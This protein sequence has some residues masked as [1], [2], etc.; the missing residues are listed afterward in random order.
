LG[1]FLALSLAGGS[2]RC[3]ARAFAS[4]AAIP[5]LLADDQDIPV[6][7]DV[8]PTQ[9]SNLPDAKAE[10][11]EQAEDRRVSRPAQRRGAPIGSCAA[12]SISR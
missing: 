7:V 8:S 6:A 3:E 4:I 11:E 2:L 12:K 9:S 10:A 1:Q 5:S